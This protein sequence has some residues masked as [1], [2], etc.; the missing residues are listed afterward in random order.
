[1]S[2]VSYVFF[3]L[4]I[5]RNM[6]WGSSS[7]RLFSWLYTVGQQVGTVKAGERQGLSRYT[8]F[9]VYS[10][11]SF[12]KLWQAAEAVNGSKWKVYARAEK[13][14]TLVFGRCWSMPDRYKRRYSAQALM[15]RY[16]YNGREA[17]RNGH[18]VRNADTS[19]IL[20]YH[21]YVDSLLFQTYL[22]TTFKEIA[23]A[24]RKKD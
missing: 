16:R 11:K 1:M 12:D 22:F 17:C 2:R 8:L 15:T 14:P 5:P 6:F 7:L 13:T 24:S 9:L 10:L 4:D 19:S 21:I 18:F 20:S 3:N 23:S